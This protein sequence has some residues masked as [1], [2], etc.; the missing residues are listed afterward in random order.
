MR[1]PC[2][3]VGELKFAF[4]LFL[5]FTVRI[6]NLSVNAQ[7]ISNS[8]SSVLF[9]QLVDLS[10]YDGIS[11]DSA[12]KVAAEIY[13]VAITDQ[14]DSLIFQSFFTIAQLYSQLET[15]DLAIEYYFL[16]LKKM[17]EKPGLFDPSKA[18]K[19]KTK[20]YSEIAYNYFE[21]KM[22]ELS[23]KY[24]QKTLDLIKKSRKQVP[25][26]FSVKDEAIIFYNI[27][28]IFMLMNEI[29]L[30]DSLINKGI[31]LNKTVKDSLIQA[32]L[33]TAT[34]LIHKMR[35]ELDSARVDYQNAI[36]ILE[37][38][39]HPGMLVA[40]YNN[41]GEYYTLKGDT[42]VAIGFYIKSYNLARAWNINRSALIATEAL[43][44]IY[45]QRRQYQPAS[46]YYRI[47]KFISDSVFNRER[48]MMTSNRS[49]EFEITREIR[50]MEHDYLQEQSSL[51]KKVMYL[52]FGLI[53]MAFLVL[54]IS[55]FF[56]HARLKN[57]R[58]L[59]QNQMREKE[60][61][62]MARQKENL[63]YNLEHKD[64]LL[65]TNAMN[66]AQK[67]ELI[68]DMH[69]RLK[70]V[71]IEVPGKNQELI[72]G[73][74]GNLKN[75]LG[76]NE[77]REFE[78]RFNEIHPDF[79]KKLKDWFPDLSPSD[80]KIAALLWLNLSSKEIASITSRTADSVKI[81]RSRLRKK[82]GLGTDENL[83]AFLQLIR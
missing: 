62:L 25:E 7:A 75:S 27:G 78:L 55:F 72:Q 58:L 35:G 60:N 81:S 30:A 31:E 19:K 15:R 80:Q 66:L 48:L 49:H 70:S 10:N 13:R 9:R 12:L 40:V 38:K 52:V 53:I 20:I 39:H 79:F 4:L 56:Q 22:N 61:E 77:W 59:L 45:Y 32:G 51:K 57:S 18:A 54:V 41:M 16:A 69:D 83:V 24:Y 73:V 14:K 6:V 65:T 82:L 11:A 76:K 36:L 63:Q 37:I 64:R 28:S 71:I 67:N 29:T 46:Q 68:R 2:I 5:V 1:S 34:G 42:S 23:V 74:I 8:S 43:S 26:A 17:E 47:S 50:Q 3:W 21:L 44:S 33:L